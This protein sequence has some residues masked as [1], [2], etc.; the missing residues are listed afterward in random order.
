MSFDDRHCE[1]APECSTV[2]R[3]RWV[4]CKNW[5]RVEYTLCLVSVE[6]VA[7]GCILPGCFI[8]HIILK[9]LP[10]RIDVLYQRKST[11]MVL[12]C[13]DVDEAT[14][15]GVEQNQREQRMQ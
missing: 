3:E 2:A 14:H 11:E 15:G 8:L 5:V 7:D 10:Q 9:H 13:I 12:R 4:V 6:G 1:F